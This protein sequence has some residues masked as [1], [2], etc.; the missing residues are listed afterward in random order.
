[1]SHDVIVVGGGAVGMAVARALAPERSVLLVERDRPG[2]QASWAAAGM[3]CPQS[4]AEEDGAL[5]RFGLDSMSMYPGWVSEL[6]DETGI[7]VEYREDGVLVLASGAEEWDA[8]GRRAAWQRRIG[9]DAELLDPDAVARLEPL[10]TLEVAGGFFCPGDHQVR[11]RRLLDALERSCM[12]RGVDVASGAGAAAVL[13]AGDAVRGVR[14]GTTEIHAP[15]V[16]VAAGAWSSSIDGLAPRVEIRPRKGQILSLRMPG[17][18]VRRIVRW[19]HLY[20]VP[21]NDDALIVGGTDE[22]AGFDRNVTAGGVAALID[23]ARR[24][25]A[26]VGA[27]PIEETWTGLRPMTPDGLPAIGEAG[28]DGLY[29]ALGHYRNGILLAPATAE[30]VRAALAGDPAASYAGAFTPARLPESV[31]ADRV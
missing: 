9:L 12:L 31:P 17:P 3:L 13:A 10:L 6:R 29:Y 28:P 20:L 18:R 1:M 15:T 2:R 23:G 7:D 14:V 8:L 19:R 30:I 11:P 27:F 16:V 5:F 26:A 22:D 24:M 21:R 25:A 4:E